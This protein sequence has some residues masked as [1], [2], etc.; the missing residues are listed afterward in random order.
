MSMNDHRRMLLDIGALN[1]T[2][3][4]LSQY[5]SILQD[6]VNTIIACLAV[7]GNGLVITV[8]LLRRRVFSSFTNRLILHQSI[9]D[10]IA[11]V[12]FFIHHVVIKTRTLTASMEGN[13]S[14]QILCRFLV[15]DFALWWVNVTSTY[16]LVV[17]SL[18]R[19]MATCHPVKHRNTWSAAKLKFA[20]ASAWGVG[21]VYNSHYVFAFEARQGYCELIEMSSGVKALY[22]TAVLAVGYFVPITILI[23]TYSR[24]LIMLRKKTLNQQAN[25]PR[26]VMTKAKKNILV[27]TML[28]GVMFVVCWTPI[29]VLYIYQ[30]FTVYWSTPLYYPFTSVLACNMFVNPI[31]YC[32]KYEHFRS[33]LRQL[34]IKR[35][36]RNR[37]NNVEVMSIA[38]AALR[39]DTHL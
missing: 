28:I 33:E 2:S 32:F 7:L 23:Y 20:V 26:I 6:A 17:I 36:R 4:D 14:D 30:R 15:S 12:L 19:F 5:P 34:I 16:N 25:G 37:V 39:M 9:I 18:E 10:T 22:H 38:V 29:E 27:T 21:L 35:C 11:G 1:S 24:I 31:I 8:M 13:V 3:E